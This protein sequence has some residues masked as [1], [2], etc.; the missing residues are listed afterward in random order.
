MFRFFL[1][2]AIGMAIPLMAA[3]LAGKWTGTIE[4]NGS[5]VPV[6]L[7]INQQDGKFSGSVATGNGAKPVTIDSAELHDDKFD[8]MSTTTLVASLNSALNSL[9]TD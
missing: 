2:M 6:L 4:T 3:S 7:T 1:V 9:A 5:R 8:S